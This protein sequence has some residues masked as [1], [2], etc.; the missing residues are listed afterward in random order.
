MNAKWKFFGCESKNK[1]R[2]QRVLFDIC[3]SCTLR[4]E[5]QINHSEFCLTTIFHVYYM[6]KFVKQEF[7]D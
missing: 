4:D 2:S 6:K 5:K 7:S 1:D 3:I